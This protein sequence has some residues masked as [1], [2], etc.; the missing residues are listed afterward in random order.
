[1]E[2][3]LKKVNIFIEE[4]GYKLQKDVVGILLY[5]SAAT[6]LFQKDSDIDLMIV[7][8]ACASAKGAYTIDTTTI[9]Y[10][11]RSLSSLEEEL[12]ESIDFNSGFL[13]SAMKN[14]ILLYD[15]YHFLEDFKR[16]VLE[17]FRFHKPKR[18]ITSDHL[19][20]ASIHFHD[21]HTA[22]QNCSPI[23][24]AVYYKAIQSVRYL[25][26]LQNGFFNIPAV[27]VP[28]LYENSEKSSSYCLYLPDDTYKNL[29]LKAISSLKTEGRSKYL[30]LL[31]EYTQLKVKTLKHIPY[32][33]Q[34]ERTFYYRNDIKQRLIIFYN[35][36]KYIKRETPNSPYL[37][38]QFHIFLE[39]FRKFYYAY[40]EI[41]FSSHSLL[42]EYNKQKDNKNNYFSAP[43]LN[44]YQNGLT[45]SSWK[46]QMLLL[47]DMIHFAN[48]LDA[49][50]NPKKYYIKL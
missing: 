20:S 9:E 13:L 6:G 29:F 21:F 24:T 37:D 11:E 1:M 43:F 12:E 25:Y 47:E 48:K 32:V 18:K 34:N 22:C 4:K 50:F 35:L 49:S 19:I 10:F 27:K 42:E 33:F 16:N 38:Y 14:G 17:F 36:K 8:M 41:P 30:D 39:A 15:P 7:K 26:H 45:A 5:G 28:L 3:I 44:L 23:K 40:A 31:W 46:E 2:E